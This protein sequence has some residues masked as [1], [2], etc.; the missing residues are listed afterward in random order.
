MIQLMLCHGNNTQTG[1]KELLQ[2]W[3][4]QPDSWI[5]V[6]L[7]DEPTE[8][9]HDFLSEQFCIDSVTITEAQRNRHPPSFQAFE[10]YIYLLLK[11]LDA[12]SDSLDFNTLQLAMF[13]SQRFLITRHSKES[14]Y[15]ARLWQALAD[16]GCADESPL[17]MVASMSRRAA[18]RYGT[19]LLN[20]EQRLDVIEDELFDTPTDTLMKELVSYNTGLRKMHRILTYHV[21]VFDNMR[22]HLHK[23]NSHQLDIFDDIFA[24]IERFNSLAGLYQNVITDLVEAY[25]SLNGHR[26]NQIMKVLTIVTVIFVPLTLLV[27]IYG[28]NFENMPELKSEHGYFILLSTMTGIAALLLYLFRR[29]RWL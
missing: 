22:R 1:G 9:E 11:P 7:Y 13:A 19:V 16:N 20:L 28:M 18:Q 8:A 15:L 12:E 27:G 24:L 10:D 17:S 26:L 2:Q 5:W 21:D 14:P 4:E 29:T 23:T 6:E 3:Q 25:I